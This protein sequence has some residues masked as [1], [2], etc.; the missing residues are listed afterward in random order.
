M[1]AIVGIAK[2]SVKVLLILA[3]AASRINASEP[4]RLLLVHRTGGRA[5]NGW[6]EL[7]RT[8]LAGADPDLF[9]P[10]G[11]RT[12]E[13]AARLL[14][15]H[16]A[17]APPAPPWVRLDTYDLSAVGDCP[18]CQAPPVDPDRYLPVDASPPLGE[19]S[20]AFFAAAA[21]AL[22]GSG[23]NL[24]VVVPWGTPVP[25]DPAPGIWWFLAPPPLPGAATPEGLAEQE[26]YRRAWNERAERVYN[27]VDDGL[28]QVAGLPLNGDLLRRA[29]AALSRP[30]VVVRDVD[31]F[32]ASGPDWLT[33]RI[34]AVVL[35]GSTTALGD[36]FR[37]DRP[38]LAV[39]ADLYE[40][41]VPRLGELPTGDD[42]LQA[43]DTLRAVVA[44][45]EQRAAGEPRQGVVSDRLAGLFGERFADFVR[46][47]GALPATRL[48]AV[49]ITLDGLRGDPG[50]ASATHLSLPCDDLG[51]PTDR[52]A[53]AWLGTDG[54][55]LVLGVTATE[56]NPADATLNDGVVLWWSP[57]P[58]G[59]V[60]R[61]EVTVAGRLTALRLDRPGAPPRPVEVH[62]VEVA[63]S[64]DG[65]GWG[66]E[67][68]LPMAL[69]ATTPGD[70]EIRFNLAS[71]HR[72][73]RE[74]RG[75][76]WCPTGGYPWTAARYPR[77][78][79]GSR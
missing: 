49:A 42:A 38:A 17:A 2:T 14:R 9:V 10:A 76:V 20:F 36:Y 13:A 77:L 70:A 34:E 65:P 29:A 32:V 48:P 28:G 19:R 71:E 27:L 8:V 37:A 50:W 44:W 46:G 51:R 47:A 78:S 15:A 73:G 58:G 43:V 35:G 72:Y 68:A 74:R 53:E 64:F 7:P 60:T 63:G 39:I 4:E 16:L 61:L 67:L 52:P 5:P 26:R 31:T 54:N 69:L 62:G 57:G 22:A 75:A 59:P 30:A 21:A 18:T 41:L 12:V 79:L 56:P 55:R 6:A 66:L 23:L 11:C 45:D 33:A 40:P 24:C 25:D 1:N 3:L